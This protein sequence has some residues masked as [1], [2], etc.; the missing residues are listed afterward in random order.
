MKALNALLAR[1]D[2]DPDHLLSYEVKQ[3]LRLLL[4]NGGLKLTRSG[5]NNAAS[6]KSLEVEEYLQLLATFRIALE[7]EEDELCKLTLEKD[8]VRY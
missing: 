7:V 5:I 6:G 1:A 4:M 8:C 2:T 3:K